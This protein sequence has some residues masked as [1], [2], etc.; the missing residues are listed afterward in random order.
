MI[1]R[2]II[3]FSAEY[4]PIRTDIAYRH[5]QGFND[6]ITS[7]SVISACDYILRGLKLSELSLTDRYVLCLYLCPFRLG[8]WRSLAVQSDEA[9]HALAS[10]TSLQDVELRE[11]TNMI[12]DIIMALHRH[13]GELSGSTLQ[14]AAEYLDYRPAHTLWNSVLDVGARLVRQHLKEVNSNYLMARDLYAGYDSSNA[15]SA[16]V[17]ALITGDRSIGLSIYASAPPMCD[18]ASYHYFLRNL[19]RSL[20]VVPAKFRKPFELAAGEMGSL[21][22]KVSWAEYTPPPIDTLDWLKLGWQ[23]GSEQDDL[24]WPLSSCL[25][26]ADNFVQAKPLCE[27]IY[28]ASTDDKARW[29]CAIRMVR[30]YT[31]VEFDEMKCTVWADRAQAIMPDGQA[32]DLLS[33][34]VMKR[35]PN[36]ALKSILT[37]L[38]SGSHRLR[39]EAALAAYSQ[40]F[41][42]QLPLTTMKDWDAVF[43]D[44]ATKMPM[45]SDFFLN[46][47]RA[48]F[49]ETIKVRDERSE[50]LE[51]DVEKLGSV[52]SLV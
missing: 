38:K 42:H 10:A 28:Y 39:Q 46:E 12:L 33:S 36:L 17:L 29:T 43:A 44:L 2:N 21:V 40:V 9:I 4:V 6:Y 41:R 22:G 26:E 30:F 34:Q 19:Q 45:F 23:F 31:Q 50:R 25:Y 20:R 32:Y 16:D 37:A 3:D 11:L 49:L 13:E 24:A 52:S 7:S 5:W 14:V 27:H 47:I 51:H 48:G 35:D 15:E 8:L 18:R 1:N